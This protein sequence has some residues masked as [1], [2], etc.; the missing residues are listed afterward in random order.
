MEC[1]K[2]INNIFDKWRLQF[3]ITCDNPVTEQSLDINQDDH[4]NC[5][6]CRAKLKNSKGLRLHMKRVHKISAVKAQGKLF[7]TYFF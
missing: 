7:N 5:E 4:F 1:S 2:E 6:K 3:S